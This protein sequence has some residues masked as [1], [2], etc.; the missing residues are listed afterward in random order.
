[1]LYYIIIN[2]R[3]ITDTNVCKYVCEYAFRQG[4]LRCACAI[5]DEYQEI[6][7]QKA[8]L[9]EWPGAEVDHGLFQ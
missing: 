5:S 1:M 3:L 9:K 2:G 4:Y 8:L 6:G 7:D